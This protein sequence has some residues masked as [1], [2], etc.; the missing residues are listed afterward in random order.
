MQLQISQGGVAL[1]S[2][3]VTTTAA[4]VQG[5]NP[6]DSRTNKYSDQS[7]AVG[8][9]TLGAVSVGNGTTATRQITGLAA[10]TADTDAVNVAQLKNVNLKYAGDTGNSDVLLKDGTL[11]VKGDT[12]LIST[13]ADATGITVTA[14]V[15]ENITTNADGKAVAPTTN[16]IATTENVTQA[17]NNSGW[18]VTSVNNGGTTNGSSSE[19]VSPGD[20]VTFSAGKNIVLDQANKQF[21]YS[22]NKDVDLTKDGSLTIGDTVINNA[23][24]TITGGPSVTKTGINAGNK[25]ITNVAPG[26]DDTDAVNVKQLKS[27]KTEVKAGAGVTVA[28]S[29]GAEGQD[30]YTVSST[31]ATGSTDPSKLVDGKNTKVEG[32]G[33][34]ATPYKVN[35]EGDLADISSITNGADSGKLTFEGDKVVKVGGDNPISLDGKGG[36][37]TGLQNKD[38]DI[39]NPT[40]VSGRAATEDQLKK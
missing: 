22:L 16:G 30:I 26:T 19:K 12:K 9:S 25:K 6:A 35:V 21:T 11:K 4:G 1:G 20:T 14:K 3:S 27:A 37:V 15:G 39:T 28:K 33:T 10:G 31:G 29:Q 36:Y 40:I 34:A 24:M 23:G 13:S 38:W 32:D 2:D 8:T 18:K 17:I 5:Y 7:G